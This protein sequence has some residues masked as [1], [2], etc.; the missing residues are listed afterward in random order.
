M[1]GHLDNDSDAI[2]GINVTPLV[3]IVLVL[4]IIFMA[5]AHMIS[6]RSFKLSLPKVAHSDPQEMNAVHV[7]LARD[8]TYEFNNTKVS[9]DELLMNLKQMVRLDPNIRVTMAADEGVSWGDVSGLLDDIKGT[10]IQRI[11][12][13]VGI[14][15]KE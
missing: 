9:R 12:A 1:A 14:K 6:H 3:D 4:L 2:T 7:T 11:A 15:K 8:K 5:T 10:G 13:D